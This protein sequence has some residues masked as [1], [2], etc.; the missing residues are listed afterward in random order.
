MAWYLV[1]IGQFARASSIARQVLGHYADPS[2]IDANVRNTCGAV[3]EHIRLYRQLRES[4]ATLSVYQSMQSTLPAGG[5]HLSQAA[6]ATPGFAQPPSTGSFLERFLMCAHQVMDFCN[7]QAIDAAREGTQYALDLFGASDSRLILTCLQLLEAGVSAAS[8]AHGAARGKLAGAAEMARLACQTLECMGY[9]RLARSARQSADHWAL[10]AGQDPA[11]VIGSLSAGDAIDLAMT[12]SLP[13]GERAAF[14]AGRAHI[15]QDQLRARLAIADRETGTSRRAAIQEFVD[16]VSRADVIRA[17]CLSSRNGAWVEQEP[18][19]AGSRPSRRLTSVNRPDVRL[20]FIVLPEQCWALVGRDTDWELVRTGF[21]AAQLNIGVAGLMNA[22]RYSGSHT[23]GQPGRLQ[24]LHHAA[25]LVAKM[26]GIDRLIEPAGSAA[27]RVQI[28]SDNPLM[29]LP[30]AMLP[31]K[32]AQLIDH[33]AVSIAFGV[34]AAALV[35][36]TQ[37]SQRPPAGR[38]ALI[39]GIGEAP[40]TGP[41]PQ[42]DLA[43]PWARVEAEEVAERARKWGLDVAGCPLFD[44]RA[45]REE[46]LRR[47]PD[48]AFLHAA[49]HGVVDPDVPERSGLL[50]LGHDGKEVRLTAQD[51]ASVNLQHLRLATLSSCWSGDLLVAPG[52]WAVGLAE[53]LHYAGAQRILASLW[54]VFDLISRPFVG[55]VYDHVTDLGAA[56]ALRAAQLA[57]RD[58][59][60]IPNLADATRDPFCW[61]GAVLYGDDSAVEW[62]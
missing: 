1:S 9:F 28:I 58:G 56:A 38:S 14:L 62:S 37:A 26:V 2:L 31:F 60:L 44:R 17:Q 51:V 45:S 41:G 16:W 12:R 30:W 32:G 27:L 23:L 34:D 18:G 19:A 35:S 24:D 3:F 43:L 36:R 6:E 49:C 57:T 11:E 54:P 8:G 61:A 21:D 39:V 46:V 55:A 29:A 50:L 20:R 7:T 53:A 59:L 22:L 33:A 42:P 25:A 5:I 4:T 47:L 15:E 13:I 48:A 52:R 10:L 40:D